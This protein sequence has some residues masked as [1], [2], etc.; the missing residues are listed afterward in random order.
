M[1]SAIETLAMSLIDESLTIAPFI[2]YFA[3]PEGRQSQVVQTHSHVVGR[4]EKL[5]G[6]LSLWSIHCKQAASDF[7]VSFEKTV[8][9][10]FYSLA[11]LTTVITCSAH[12][13][14]HELID[15]SEKS[16][17]V[18]ALRN[19]QA[20]FLTLVN[21]AKDGLEKLG[22][23][24]QDAFVEE[25]ALYRVIQEFSKCE[26]DLDAEF[27]GLCETI[28]R[29]DHERDD[30][31]SAANTAWSRL[32]DTLNELDSLS[33]IKSLF[34]DKESIIL[35]LRKDADYQRDNFMRLEHMSWRLNS[36]SKLEQIVLLDL[37]IR[38]ENLQATMHTLQTQEHQLIDAKEYWTDIYSSLST[39]EAYIQCRDIQADRLDCLRH[40]LLLLDVRSEVVDKDRHL[41]EAKEEIYRR[42]GEHFTEEELRELKE[43]KRAL[44]WDI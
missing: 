23:R 38:I 40:I 22:I 8:D 17:I 26:Q 42:I 14:D 39:M 11:D 27:K 36:L 29:V 37:K 25:A 13:E 12:E 1:K 3:D 10:A 7:D 20:L 43:T 31:S 16:D 18:S 21:M 6:E 41:I 2:D 34:T 35:P 44:V 30:A 32:S 9:A 24:S 33:I 15:P 5:Q 4:M 28:N 19:T